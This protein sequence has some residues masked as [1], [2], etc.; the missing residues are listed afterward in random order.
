MSWIDNNSSIIPNAWQ[1]NILAGNTYLLKQQNRT[2]IQGYLDVSGG[3]IILRNGGL[4]AQTDISCNRNIY[5]ANCYISSNVGIGTT[6]P[7]FKLDVNGIINGT[8]LYVGGTAYIGSQWTTTSPHI[9]YTTGN[10]AIGRTLP[11]YTL[12]VNGNINATGNIIAGGNI[13]ASSFN[14]TS[15]YR[16]KANIIPLNV[17]I[18]TINNLNP[19]SYI[20]N[21]TNQEFGFIAHEI[22]EQYPFLVTG[23]K[24]EIDPHT[25]KP[26]YQ[27]VNYQAII[28][29][30]VA[31]VKELKHT[32]QKQQRQINTF[33]QYIENN[34]L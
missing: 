24:D 4:F 25:N 28:P 22:Q 34:A 5:G 14:A 1:A 29:I 32:V 19:V 16:I 26:I 21:H 9:Y 30:L 15:D 11:Y 2:L 31:E 17:S 18:H 20:K 12:D 33:L 23:E 7:G 3:N 8:A 13:T 27:S 10:V 6:N